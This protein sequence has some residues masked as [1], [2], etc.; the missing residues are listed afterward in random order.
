MLT[1]EFEIKLKDGRRAVIR[2]PRADDAE[3]M[4]EYLFITAGDTEYLLR[5]PEECGKYTPDGERALIKR[6]NS[7]DSE[8]MLICETDGKIVGVSNIM[9]TKSIK[10]RHRATVAI[11]VVKDY[12]GFGIG[13]ALFG[14]LIRI[15]KENEN[16]L[17]LE[18]DYIEGNDRARALYEKLGFRITGVKPDAIRLKDGTLLNEYSM[19]KKLDR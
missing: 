2:N 10:T 8:A 17:Q 1:K 14:E 15:A 7:S 3:K 4:L 18:L 9:W 11:A 16:I 6:I 13:T 19:V 5:Y 12:W